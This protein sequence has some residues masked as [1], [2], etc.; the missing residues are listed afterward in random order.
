M[1]LPR[2]LKL[3]FVPWLEDESIRLAL[4][5]SKMGHTLSRAAENLKRHPGPVIDQKA[6]R[7][8]KGIGP[9]IVENLAAKL[10]KHCKETGVV[11]IP[12]FLREVSSVP[13][14]KRRHS[15]VEKELEQS[16]DEESAPKKTRKARTYIPKKHSGG[17]AMLLALLKYDLRL[18]GMLRDELSRKASPFCTATFDSNA[19]TKEFYSAWNS[20][21]TLINKG[22]VKSAG[23]P[24]Y[25]YLTEEGRELAES[26]ACVSEEF[27]EK[28]PV[29]AS[30]ILP[31]EL[32]EKK[33]Q[34][35]N[36]KTRDNPPIENPLDGLW[37]TPPRPSF[38]SNVS[39]QTRAF[40]PLSGTA[41]EPLVPSFTSTS[42]CVY[43]SFGSTR[44]T[45]WRSDD[46]TVKLLVD[47]R[48]IRSMG[49]RDYFTK[50]LK[51]L[52]IDC[53]STQL[54]VGDCLWVAEHKN[55]EK[56]VLDFILE[57]KR[58]DDLALSIRDGRFSEQKTRLKRTGIQNCF[59]LIEEIASLQVTQMIEAIQTAIS[60]TMTTSKFFVKRSKDADDTIWFLARL[61]QT[62]IK[63]Y[64]G[65]PLLVLKPS[66]IRTQMLYL[67]ILQNFRTEY[68]QAECVYNY[69][70]FLSVMAKSD[71]TTVREMFIRMLMTIRGVSLDKAVVI[72]KRFQTP[73]RLLEFYHTEHKDAEEK[74]KTQL[75]KNIFGTE[76]GNKKIG[77]ALSA[78]I[79][80][81]WGKISY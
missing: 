1:E 2:D 62:I 25:Y 28:D 31:A 55:G 9:K 48:E 35:C 50:K 76:V 75:L 36:Q 77:P 80:E 37:D 67:E 12:E 59:Y 60:M 41:P 27:P 57:R 29:P 7:S 56:C 6:L 72:Q 49:Q 63:A 81:T 52:G 30:D 42:P 39:H 45:T 38:K 24:V 4:T 16:F 79:Y 69:D 15:D 65:K 13:K 64:Q 22:L 10:S 46:Y 5:G 32:T 71:C 20:M 73:R 47:N 3:L 70:I 40:A 21:K 11:D 23:R 8:V 66:N 54:T 43:Q 44:Y 17:Y 19:L 51:E 68:P 74:V 53:D 14:P 33:N 18:T 61:T 26:L 58:L 34:T 78:K